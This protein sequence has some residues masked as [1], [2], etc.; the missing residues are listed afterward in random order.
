MDPETVTGWIGQPHMVKKIEKTFG[1][2]VANMQNYTTL[3]TP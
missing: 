3:G 1:K 2:E